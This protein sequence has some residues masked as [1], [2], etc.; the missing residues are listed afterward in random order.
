MQT[1]KVSRLHMSSEFA[2]RRLIQTFVHPH[3]L[4][5]KH[6]LAVA[7]KKIALFDFGYFLRSLYISSQAVRV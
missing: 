6:T 4:G 7:F 1:Y 3:C 5:A 2:Q